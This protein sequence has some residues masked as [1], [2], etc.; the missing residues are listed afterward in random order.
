[1]LKAEEE[2]EN[3]ACG[4]DTGNLSEG[5]QLQ[6]SS[7]HRGIPEHRLAFRT[8][9]PDPP[10]ATFHSNIIFCAENQARFSSALIL[11]SARCVDEP[12]G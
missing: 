10:L 7:S 6:S 2:Q 9:P 1:M 4:S 12:P 3:P 11:L 8:P 5:S